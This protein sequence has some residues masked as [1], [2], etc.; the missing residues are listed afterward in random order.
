MK[1]RPSRRRFPDAVIRRRPPVTVSAWGAPVEADPDIAVLPANVQPLG[2][3]RDPQEL[4][5]QL[6]ERLAVF[7]PFGVVILVP[8]DVL[9]WDGRKLLIRGRPWDWQLIT[10]AA[11]PVPLAAAGDDREGDRVEFAG[12]RYTVST[13]E[14]WPGYC[15]AT[16][17]RE[18]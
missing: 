7:C 6:V 3:E 9:T 15:K 2:L 17:I 5:T 4:G 13:A 16:V 14:T 11:E 12:H 10:Q 1:T 18:S 8:E